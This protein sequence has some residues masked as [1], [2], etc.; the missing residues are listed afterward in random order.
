MLFNLDG[1]FLDH[2][3][4]KPCLLFSEF[5]KGDFASFVWC[6]SQGVL[7]LNSIY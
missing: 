5:Q 6:Y 7:G 1:I 4:Q 2:Y 3:G